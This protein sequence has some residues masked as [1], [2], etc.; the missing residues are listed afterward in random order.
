MCEMWDRLFIQ[1]IWP[2]QSRIQSPNVH[3]QS[4]QHKVLFVR[5]QFVR[6]KKNHWISVMY[7]Y[8]LLKVPNTKCQTVAVDVQNGKVS[9]GVSLHNSNVS[10][11]LV[12]SNEDSS[13]PPPVKISRFNL[14][15]ARWYNLTYLT[16][17]CRLSS[18][19]IFCASGSN[20]IDPTDLTQRERESRD[21]WSALVCVVCVRNLLLLLLVV[22]FSHCP[23]SLEKLQ[24][25]QN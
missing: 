17:P 15:N 13:V 21:D 19:L 18:L 2:C 11:P 9:V 8:L 12:T 23:K 25:R 20:S 1:K 5:R 24:D 6:K 7:D 4:S 16:R 10:S 3:P 22:Y 14:V